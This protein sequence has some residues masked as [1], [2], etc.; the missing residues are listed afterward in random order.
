MRARPSHVRA[1]RSSPGCRDGQQPSFSGQ[2]L[3]SSNRQPYKEDRQP[4]RS[5]GSLSTKS[6]AFSSIDGLSSTSQ[7]PATTTSFV[8]SPGGPSPCQSRGPPRPCLCSSPETP[9][10]ARAPAAPPALPREPAHS[11]PHQ[12]NAPPAAC[13]ARVA[14]TCCP[15]HPGGPQGSQS[16]QPAV[17][18]CYSRCPPS[19]SPAA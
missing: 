5:F 13:R 17:L 1:S 18:T 12:V 16:Y 9:A 2:K 7:R 3:L 11:D 14:R 10:A 15:L 8:P 19:L 4:S 6:A